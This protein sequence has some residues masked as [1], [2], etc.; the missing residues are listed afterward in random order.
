MGA[1]DKILPNPRPGYQEPGADIVNLFTKMCFLE[2]WWLGYA[3]D[4]DVPD[5]ISTMGEVV[6]RNFAG[7]EL[8]NAQ[9]ILNPLTIS[10]LIN[11][12]DSVVPNGFWW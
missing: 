3:P 4:F 12:H 9:K 11:V 2:G 5:L 10:S 7:Q 6:G 8:A 1:K